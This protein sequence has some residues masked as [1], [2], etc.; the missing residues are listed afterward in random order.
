MNKLTLELPD[1]TAAQLKRLADRLGAPMESLATASVIEL[2]SR[3]DE[4]FAE[5]LRK[6][7]EKNRE[8]YRRLA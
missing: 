2:V 8:L 3:P 6:V 4:R 5:V 7:L 1:E